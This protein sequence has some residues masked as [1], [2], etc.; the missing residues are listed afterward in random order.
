MPRHQP[1]RSGPPSRRTAPSLLRAAPLAASTVLAVVNGHSGGSPGSSWPLDLLPDSGWVA[2]IV[3]NDRDGASR[4]VARRARGDSSPHRNRTH[5]RLPA[6]L[7]AR[8]AHSKE[9]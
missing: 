9:I 5:S 4:P 6:S 1:S 2:S 3:G 8:V 7:T